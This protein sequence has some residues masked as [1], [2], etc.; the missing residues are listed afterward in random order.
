MN[1]DNLQFVM[2]IVFCSIFIIVIISIIYM[3]SSW[4]RSRMMKKAIKM[5][6][7]VIEENEDDLR[8]L[9]AKS[10]DIQREGIEIKARAIKDGL[11]S[12]SGSVYCKYCGALIDDDSVF[13]RKCG[14][15]Q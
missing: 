15:E 8:E 4:G 6:K 10:A 7:S 9:S 12:D 11:T 1:I 14:K 2:T 13:C 5:E 3:S